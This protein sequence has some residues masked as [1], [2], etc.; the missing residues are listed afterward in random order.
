MSSDGDEWKDEE[1]IYNEMQRK[2][3]NKIQNISDGYAKALVK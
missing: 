3:A 2:V 1:D